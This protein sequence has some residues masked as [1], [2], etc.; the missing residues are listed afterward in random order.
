MSHTLVSP[1]KASLFVGV[2]SLLLIAPS[3][4][5]QIV[6]TP[7]D[8]CIATFAPV[9]YNGYA[10]YWCGDSWYYR[11]GGGWGIY[12]TEPAFLVGHRGGFRGGNSPGRQFYGRGR[13]GGGARAGGGF[14]G[15]GGGHG[16]GGRR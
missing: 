1:L 13:P 7:P 9:Y 12:A 4:Q 14:R 11:N 8:A 2:L 10:S 6:I 16:G 15:G 3:V 5:A